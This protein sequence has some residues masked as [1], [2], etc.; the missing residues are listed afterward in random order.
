MKVSYFSLCKP[1][2]KIICTVI[3]LLLASILAAA[4]ETVLYR[5]Q[6]GNDG[7]E[8]RAGLIADAAGNLYGTTFYGGSRASVGTIFRLTP[9]RRRGASW[10]ETVLHTFSDLLGG[11]DPWAGLIFDKAGNLYGTTWLGGTSGDCGVVFE[12]SPSGGSWTYTVIHNFACGGV[13]DGGEPRADLVMDQSGNLFGTTSVGGTGSCV[14][15][16]GVVFELSPS[17]G[18]WT[19][20]V[21][22]N[23]Q[24]TFDQR[25]GTG[26]GVVLDKQGNL[27]GTNYRGNVR[28]AAGAVFELKRPPKEG[29]PWR[30]KVIHDFTNLTDGAFPSAGVVF[31]VHGN[32]YGT[33]EFGAGSGCG[34]SGCGVVFELNP[35]STGTWAYAV[36][37][38]FAGNGDGGLPQAS[39]TPGAGGDL[40][41][42]T[43][44]GGTGAG[45]SGLGCGVAFRLRPPHGPGGAWTETVL[46]TFHGGRDGYVPW[47]KPAFGKGG[48]LYGTTQFGGIPTCEI[49]NFGCGTVFEIIP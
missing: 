40:Y 4:Q 9:P 46:H 47:G 21:L 3:L 2:P 10:S 11:W 30:Y 36:L 24:A 13:S 48:R 49:D 23:F 8:P 26:G 1:R 7:S 42:T 6:S 38:R 29:G 44:E 15:G 33:T 35:N 32:L 27:Y 19:E 16:C 37:Y 22:Y 34:G 25:G 41:G 31:D 18:G 20:T 12:L 17:N 39:L 45:C 43:Q 28:N 5:F 14:G